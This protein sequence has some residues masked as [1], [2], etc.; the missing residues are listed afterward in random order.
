MSSSLAYIAYVW[1]TNG[2][3]AG[4]LADHL[5]G[6]K[7]FHR[8][9]LRLEMLLRHPWIVDASKAVPGS[10]AETWTKSYICRPGAWSVLLLCETLCHQ[11]GPGDR[12][13]W[14]ALGD[15][16]FLLARVVEMYTSR[17]G[18]WVDGHVL[19][20]RDVVLFRGRTQPH[21]TMLCQADRIEV[22]F[23]SSKGDQL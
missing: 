3:T 13:L 23:R 12:V 1:G 10:P 17:E 7:F 15:S 11:S 9:E 14:L 22:Q 18:C 5:A 19:P 16:F 21:W 8:Q 4:T 2:L 20:Q 6:V